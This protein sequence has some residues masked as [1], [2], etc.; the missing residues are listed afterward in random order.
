MS[1][2]KLFILVILNGYL[3]YSQND[4]LTYDDVLVLRDN[5]GITIFNKDQE[6]TFSGYLRIVS[7]EKKCYRKVYKGKIVN[8]NCLDNI[9]KNKNS[10]FERY[11]KQIK[12]KDVFAWNQ[13]KLDSIYLKNENKEN[14]DFLGYN[15]TKKYT[16]DSKVFNGVVKT[17]DSLFFIEDGKI[18]VISII[19]PNG[20]INEIYEVNDNKKTGQYRKYSEYNNLIIEGYF[21]SNKKS[22][23]WKIYNLDKFDTIVSYY[24]NNM[25]VRIWLYYTGGKLVKCEYYENGKLDYYY[26]S[27]YDNNKEIRYYYRHNKK[28]A[29]AVYI[30]DKLWDYNKL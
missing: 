10:N 12:K 30:D 17:N 4:T 25:P 20:E 18:C 16:L 6:S 26:T 27:E 3:S 29:L 7:E 15:Y 11:L 22:K 23:E 8:E 24:R 28:Y 13:L 1:K 9:I 2:I 14:E 21:I 19:Y 5:K